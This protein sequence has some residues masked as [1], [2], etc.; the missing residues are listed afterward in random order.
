[1]PATLRRR[2]E[3]LEVDLSTCSRGGDFMDTLAKVKEVPGRRFHVEPAIRDDGSKYERK[4]WLLPDEPAIAE[5]IV[6]AVQPHRD[7]KLDEWIREA[8]QE[9]EAEL[10]STLPDDADDLLIPWA[11]ERAFW[12]PRKIG[13][14]VYSGLKPH[15]RAWVSE[16]QKVSVLRTILADDMGLGKTLQAISAVAER[17]LRSGL[18]SVVVEHG[19]EIGFSTEA[20]GPKLIVCPNSVKGVWAREITR[21]L[22]PAE[23]VQIIDGT[24]PK[25][26]HNQLVRIIAENGWAIVNY[27]QLRV[28][29]EKIKTRA[30]GTKTVEKMKEPLFEKTD[31]YAVIADEVHRAKNRKAAQTRGLYRTSKG[32]DH[33]I[34]L[35]ATGTP[36]MNNPADLWSPLHWLYPK[37]Y[38]SYWRFYETYVDYT[39]GYFGKIINGVRNPDAL[40]FELQGRL[41]RRTKDQVLDLP[42]KVR[43]VVPVYLSPK[44]RKLYK[45]IETALWVE[46]EQAV[47]EGDESATK[48]A[49]AA[50]GGTNV[51]TIPNGAARL[52]RL[53]QMLSTMALLGGEDYSDKLDACLEVILDN[54]HKPHVVFTEFKGTCDILAERLSR[55][56][57]TA[58][59]YNG[60]TEEHQRT[61]LE[62]SFQSGNIDV[63]VG[64]I[65]AMREGITLTAAD[66]S[67]WI[68]VPWVPGWREQGEDR[69]HRIGQNN[70]VTSI[71]YEAVDTVDDGVIAPTNRLKERIVKTVLP[72]DEIKETTHQ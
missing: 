42:D 56:G 66:T 9:Y 27:E 60:D 57:L 17:A 5:R 30:G 69:L 23:P 12:Q 72:K 15:Q 39:E 50:A 55:K 14:N 46:I 45:E 37:E 31:W 21:W 2:D 33:R 41:Y 20:A 7:P 62:E 13:D 11:T 10:V 61:K 51:Y 29:K 52:V 22:G 38:T 35:G 58:A 71:A 70:S 34:L 26:R 59:V 49:E 47:T 32:S 64:T 36:L 1:M 48:L 43:M 44:A 16:A 24:T 4:V 3:G 25:A 8:K 40:R 6:H 28:A 18:A 53:R 65:G 67:H 54:A 63:L 68:E 19:E